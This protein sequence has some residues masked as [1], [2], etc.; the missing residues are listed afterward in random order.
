MEGLMNA[1]S[2][3]KND[4]ADRGLGSWVLGLVGLTA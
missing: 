3:E 4:L 1:W 2:V